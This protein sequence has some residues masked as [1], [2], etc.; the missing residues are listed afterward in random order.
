MKNE[1]FTTTMLVNASPAEAFKAINNV[2]GWWSSTLKGNTEKLNDEF[3]YQY[4]DMHSSTQ[5]LVEVVPDKKVVWLVSDS[6]LSFIMQKDEWDGTT[7]S[8][9][10][11]PKAEQTEIVFTH[12]GLVPSVECYDACYGGWSHYLHE[13]LVPLINTGKGNPD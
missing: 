3:H 4:K 5:K 6:M 9:E 11:S 12:H 7:I 8:F 2:R 1:D 10:L 13:S